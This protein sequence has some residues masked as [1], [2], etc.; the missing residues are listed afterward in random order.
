M[1]T[2]ISD[3]FPLYK[4]DCQ[5]FEICKDYEPKKCNYTSPCELRQ[6]LREVLE[7]FVAKK[8]LELQIKLIKN[9]RNKK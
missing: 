9:D 6:W 8:N 7:P 2:W 4:L 5:Y 3:N 1:E